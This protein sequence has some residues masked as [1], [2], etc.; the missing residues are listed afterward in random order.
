[1]TDPLESAFKKIGWAKAHLAPFDKAC[2]DFLA[3]APFGCRWDWDSDHEELVIRFH[4]LA[5]PPIDIA[6]MAGDILH[7]ARSALNHA[8]YGLAVTHCP[9]LTNKERGKLQFPIVSGPSDFNNEKD[10]MGRLNGVPVKHQLLIE[11]LQPY[12][13]AGNI[14]LKLLTELDNI[15][16]HHYLNVVAGCVRQAEFGYPTGSLTYVQWAD[17][18]FLKDA[19]AEIVRL[20]LRPGTR[21]SDLDFD[22][23]WVLAVETKEVAPEPP[24]PARS[25][26]GR[27]VVGVE[28]ALIRLAEI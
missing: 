15:D 3:T 10:N 20:T 27:I 28:L 19:N 23:K 14:P 9:T 13:G 6:L 1:M 16:K 25:L 17:S 4:P 7:N 8:V 21:P 18:P 22:P 2:K 5:S 11:Q 26:L 12:P 24:D